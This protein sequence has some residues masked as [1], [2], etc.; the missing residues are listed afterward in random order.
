[1]ESVACPRLY[2]CMYFGWCGDRRNLRT[3]NPP[4]VV[5]GMINNMIFL[6]VSLV[7]GCI[8]LLQKS[9]VSTIEVY[10]KM[11][12]LGCTGRSSN[13]LLLHRLTSTIVSDISCKFRHRLCI[14]SL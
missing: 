12:S 10:I 14:I 13:R 1:M 11:T 8:G 6:V 2:V 7:E 4:G 3:Q 9:P 5:L